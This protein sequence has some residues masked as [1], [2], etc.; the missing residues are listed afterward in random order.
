MRAVEAIIEEI[1]FLHKHF[2]ITHIQ[3]ADELLMASEK[4]TAEVC[5]AILEMDFPIKWDCNGRL[6]YAKQPLLDLMKRSGCEYINYGIESLNQKMLNDMGKGLTV[7]QIHN[8]VQAT[9]DVGIAPGLNIIWGFPG[10]TKENLWAGVEFLKRYDP[11]HELRTIRPV[12]PYPG[13][14]LYAKAVKDGLLGGA[15]DFYEKRHVNSDLFTVDFMGWGMDKAHD[16]LYKANLALYDNYLEQ[17]R[18]EFD[19]QA[20]KLYSGD[21]EGFR[22]WR[23]V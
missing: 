14:E 4:R 19:W 16:E 5:E 6:N 12:T 22:G 2:G 3:F 21:S 13:T 8:G 1:E 11:C 20:A 18:V 17:K 15:Y 23:D 7:T 9:L 10:D